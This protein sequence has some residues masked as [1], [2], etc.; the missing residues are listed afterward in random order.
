MS[1]IREVISSRAALR[2]GIHTQDTNRRGRNTDKVSDC[3]CFTFNVTQTTGQVL[4]YEI[5]DPES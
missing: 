1:E 3:F 2:S 4:K 5:S